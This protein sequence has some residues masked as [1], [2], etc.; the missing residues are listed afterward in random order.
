M[1]SFLLH[2]R[3]EPR[4]CG[5]AFAS[6]KGHASP[7]RG[8]AATSSC[9]SGG[10]ELWWLV[11][12]AGAEEALALLPHYVARRCDAIPIREVHIP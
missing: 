5:I 11:E 12:A 8:R 9:L 4:E 10:H 2:H 1:A 3:H 6:F 7:L